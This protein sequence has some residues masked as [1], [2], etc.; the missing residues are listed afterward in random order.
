MIAG[1]GIYH[2]AAESIYIMFVLTANSKN[3]SNTVAR[4]TIYFTVRIW[5]IEELFNN[6]PQY[7]PGINKQLPV[8]YL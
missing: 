7:K 3:Y 5:D 1:I 2:P 6:K 4:A 8:L